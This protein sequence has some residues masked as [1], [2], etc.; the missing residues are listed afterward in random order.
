MWVG[1]F[2]QKLLLLVG[3][4]KGKNW[5]SLSSGYWQIYLPCFIGFQLFVKHCNERRT[6]A[7]G[8]PLQY[9]SLLLLREPGVEDSCLKDFSGHLKSFFVALQYCIYPKYS[10]TSTPHHT[11]SKISTSITYYPLLCLKIAGLTNSVDPDEMPHSSHCLL[12]LVCPNTYG[13]YG[14]VGSSHFGPSNSALASSEIF[15]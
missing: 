4:F 7:C 5:P 6:W 12:M 3:L 9:L 8:T 11:C 13:K 10:N 2:K 14:Y 1:F 15:Y